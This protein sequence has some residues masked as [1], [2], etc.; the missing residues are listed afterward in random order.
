[1]PNEQVPPGARNTDPTTSHQAADSVR[2]RARSQRDI[3]LEAYIAAPD[4]GLIDEEA[5]QLAEVKMRSCWWKRCSELRELGFTERIFEDGEP[6]VRR[7]SLG[8]NCGVSR[9]TE[10]GV[11]HL[12]NQQIIP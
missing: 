10:A 6:V 7:S 11:L 12:K 8:E 3:L 1:M 9:I 5:A 4:E 2:R